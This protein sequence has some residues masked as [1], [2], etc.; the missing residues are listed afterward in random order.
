MNP[1][2]P[3][4]AL[5]LHFKCCT[6]HHQNKA[7]AATAIEVLAPWKTFAFSEIINDKL[8]QKGMGQELHRFVI[9]WDGPRMFLK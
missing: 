2:P 4:Y 6:Y 5:D 7:A 3:G 9:D 1:P 8:T